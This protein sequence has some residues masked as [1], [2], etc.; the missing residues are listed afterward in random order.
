[1]SGIG[2]LSS[3]IS[4]RNRLWPAHHVGQRSDGQA[5]RHARPERADEHGDPGLSLPQ[6]HAGRPRGIDNHLGDFVPNHMWDP[7][8]GMACMDYAGVDGPNETLVNYVTN[9]VYPHNAGVFLNITDQKNLPG[10]HCARRYA[11]RTSKMVCPTR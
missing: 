3:S 5:Q 4:W 8:E 9:Q 10:L 1:M 7:G 2:R 6:R 11:P